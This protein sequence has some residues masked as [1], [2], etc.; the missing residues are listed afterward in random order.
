M[1]TRKTF[2]PFFRWLKKK[3][4]SGDCAPHSA[5]VFL[6]FGFTIIGYLL[7]YLTSPPGSRSSN[8]M[9][10]SIRR[11]FD[12]FLLLLLWEAETFFSLFS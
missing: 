5:G 4:R 7:V 2:F 8:G 12:I 10:H 11:A 3:K 1:S 9:K 6:R